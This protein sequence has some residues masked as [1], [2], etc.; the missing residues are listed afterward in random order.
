MK[1]FEKGFKEA[2]K[3]FELR[4]YGKVFEGKQTKP[5]KNMKRNKSK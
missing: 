3:A 5:T 2:K 4:E 1:K